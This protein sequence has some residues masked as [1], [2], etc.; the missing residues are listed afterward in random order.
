MRF[1]LLSVARHRKFSQM[2]RVLVSIKKWDSQPLLKFVVTYRQGGKRQA[3]YF[4]DAKSAKAFAQEKQ[5]ELLNEGRKHGEITEEERRTV[6]AAR[7]LDERL[8]A[9]GIKGFALKAA[10]DH[11]AAHLKALTHSTTVRKAVEELIEIREAEGRSRVHIVDTRHRLLKFAR[12][13]DGRL[14]ASVTTK[15]VSA[16]LLGLHCAPQTR[17]NYRRA[18]HNLFAFCVS[19]GYSPN[20]PITNAVK[21]KVPPAA[22]GI[23]TT[24]EARRLLLACSESILPAVAIGF[25]AGLRRE[26]IARLDWREIDLERS[27][28]EVAAA[29]SKTTQRR[30]VAISDNLRAWLAPF[31]QLAGPVRPPHITYRRRFLEALKAAGIDRWPNNALRHTYASNHLAFHQ[32]AA[33]TALQLGHVESRTLFRHYRELVRPNEASAF[34]QISPQEGSAI[35]SKVMNLEAA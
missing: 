22:I 32:D 34:W 13:H 29:K 16:W 2:R 12:A 3:R 4:K 35:E 31:R 28:I 6:I 20:N 24:S 9:E 18:L 17:D 30:L 26:E 23:L 8:A 11:Y 1:L 33:K 27:F 14:V 25:F 5:V 10:V 19:R 7:E 21:V 15:E